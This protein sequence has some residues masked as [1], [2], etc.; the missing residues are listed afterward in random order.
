[1]CSFIVVITTVYINIMYVCVYIV[2]YTHKCNYMYIYILC[3]EHVYKYICF[4]KCVHAASG[5]GV[6][7]LQGTKS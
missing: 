1:M 6:L 3:M 4:I 2:T 5:A 7:S